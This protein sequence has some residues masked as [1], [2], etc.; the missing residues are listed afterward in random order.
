MAKKSEV[1]L[2]LKCPFCNFQANTTLGWKIH[3][4]NKHGFTYTFWHQIIAE[5]E[6][7]EKL[8]KEQTKKIKY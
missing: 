8:K 5:K 1:K 6:E 4:K 3:I 2:L 7:Q